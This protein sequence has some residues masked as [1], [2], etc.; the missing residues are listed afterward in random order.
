VNREAPLGLPVR[1][2]VVML[3]APKGCI[4]DVRHEG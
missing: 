2:E 4:D 3:K 1:G